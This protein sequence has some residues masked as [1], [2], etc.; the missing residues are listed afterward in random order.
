MRIGNIFLLTL[1]MSVFTTSAEIPAGYY[2]ACVGKKQSALKSQLYAIIKNHDRISYGSSGTWGAFRD[3]DVRSDGTVWDIYTDDAVDMPSSG[4]A[5][6]MNIEH[7]FPK[8]WWGGSKND[9]YCDIMHLMPVNST[10][11]SRRSNHP[12]GEVASETWSNSRSKVGTPKSGQGGGV[13]TVFEPDD[14]YKGDLARTYFYM[15]TCYQNLTWQGNGLLTA[16]NGTYPTLQSWAIDML[17]DWHRNDPVSQKEI[18]RNEAVYY[19]QGNR[20][21]FIDYPDMVEYIWGTMQSVEWTEEGG[22]LPPPSQDPVLTSPLPNDFYSFGEVAYGESVQI[23]IPVLGSNF[24]HSALATLTG[25]DAQMFSLI[26]ANTEMNA[27]TLT[28]NQINSTTGHVLKVRYTPT[29]ITAEDLAHSA[30]IELTSTDLA[31]PITVYIQGSCYEKQS[32][33]PVVALEATD[34]TDDSY[35][36]N[37][38]PS[39][40]DIDYYTVYRNVWDEKGEDIVITEDY[41]VDASETS[42][43]MFGRMADCM[44]TYTVTATKNGEESE[45]SKV[46][47]VEATNS[48][49]GVDADDSEAQYFSPD[50]IRLIS[51]P[52]V[53]GVYVVRK[54]GKTSKITVR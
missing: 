43:K 13:S 34:I 45:H 14:E 19:H 16:A 32:V 53:S 46:I 20:N 1:L 36:A 21:P 37:W 31:E 4:S 52:T 42:L 17:L 24:K 15:V 40:Q 51:K 6:G 35:V 39:A 44:E 38:M 18:D 30:V 33:Q 5:S 54:G 10:V 25:D 12:Y 3:T 23:E 8:S 29:S 2:D 50:G 49:V 22:V 48:I 28:A 7:T 47:M 11:N 27:L 9:A 41:E 26:F